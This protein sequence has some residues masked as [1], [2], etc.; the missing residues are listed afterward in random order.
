MY[1]EGSRA[2]GLAFYTGS[3][4]VY[5]L[6]VHADAG[7]SLIRLT[8]HAFA[9]GALAPDAGSAISGVG[10]AHDAGAIHGY[11]PAVHARIGPDSLWV[12]RVSKHG[13]VDNALDARACIAMAQYARACLPYSSS[14][15]TV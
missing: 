14:N 2:V 15:T 3:V 13:G 8:I 6:A 5:R 10:L 4:V 9:G 12:L 1:C 11:R 7:D